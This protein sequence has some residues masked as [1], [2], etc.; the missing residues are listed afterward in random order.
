MKAADARPLICHVVFRFDVGGLENGVINLIN[1]LPE[2]RWRHA[3]IA[4]DDVSEDFC[5]RM[6]RRDVET[7][8][9]RKA[10]GHLVREYA[11]LARL[12]RGLRPSIVHTRNLAALE[13]V[14]PALL[15]GVPVRIH[16]EHGWDVGDLEGASGRHQWIRRAY[17]PFVSR[18][19]A[20]SQHLARYLVDRVGVATAAVS[21]IYN[22]VDT[23]R[24]APAPSGRSA[25]DGSLF[26][27]ESHW[28]VGTVGRLQAV[29]DQTTLARAFV[30]A[31]E[32][33]SCARA[34]L[35]L[36]V[37]GD[38]PLRET[39]MQVLR[40][41]K[42]E[43]LAWFAGTRADVPAVMR[44]LDCFV[45]P[46]LAEGISNTIL[47]AMASALPIVATQVGGNSELITDGREGRL[48][49]ATHFEQMAVAILE[50]F[51]DAGL[52]RRHAQ[53]ARLRAE[54]HFSLDRMVAEY[55]Q[56]YER[57]LARVGQYVPAPAPVLP[58][59]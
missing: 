6:Q 3:V 18:Y 21:Q 20:L 58:V 44:G 54:R 55:N 35:R 28:L 36:V 1:D 2:R 8:A 27:G 40:D 16:S 34:R 41:A 26:T 53:A 56:L 31:L 29:K 47:E 52:A 13:A 30:R 46:S 38:G 32:I 43:S 4:L 19:V 7:I 23:V 14:V 33:D 39:V 49:P 48:V 42:A 59:S 25:I 45:L 15:A 24:F 22:G 12:L 9:V 51:R 57:E 50:Y 5:R 37:A 17:R 11:R 10:T